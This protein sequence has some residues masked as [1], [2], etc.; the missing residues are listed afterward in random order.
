MSG[1]WTLYLGVLCG[2]ANHD[3]AKLRV[4]D[5]ALGPLLYRLLTSAW[6]FACKSWTFKTFDELIL[7]GCSVPE[8]L[9]LQID[10]LYVPVEK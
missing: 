2:I 5:E 1:M 3:V 10:H 9:L 8:R 6:R 7:G 4:R